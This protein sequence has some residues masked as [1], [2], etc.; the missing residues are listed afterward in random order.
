MEE[1]F[2]KVMNLNEVNIL[3]S[4]SLVVSTKGHFRMMQLSN[5]QKKISLLTVVP[6]ECDVAIVDNR[7]H[8]EGIAEKGADPNVLQQDLHKYHLNDV[9]EH[10][11]RHKR[12]AVNVERVLPLHR[13]IR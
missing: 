4:A 7:R 13:L 9:K 2:T 6:Q 3:V 10:D 1:L 5:E 8:I 12:V 11:H